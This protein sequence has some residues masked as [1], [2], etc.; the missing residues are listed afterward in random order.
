MPETRPSARP[1][2]GRDSASLRDF[3]PYPPR[4]DL[5][6]L[7]LDTLR[8]LALGTDPAVARSRIVSSADSLTSCE[9][10]QA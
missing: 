3:V 9:L 6:R 4:V 5:D 2:E 8:A 7:T 10:A 1:S